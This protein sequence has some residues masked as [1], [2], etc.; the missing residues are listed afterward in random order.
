MKM[1]SFDHDADSGVHGLRHT[2]IDGSKVVSTW[3]SRHQR[4]L[5]IACLHPTL[6]VAGEFGMLALAGAQN[7]FG[8]SSTIADNSQQTEEI[9]R[10]LLSTS[11]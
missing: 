4:G 5:S 6:F 2:R 9:Q 10:P 11:C 1:T 7:I 3:R 8:I